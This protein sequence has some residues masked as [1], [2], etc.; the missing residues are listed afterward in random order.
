MTLLHLNTVRDQLPTHIWEFASN[1]RHYDLSSYES[2]HD[3]WL[4]TLTIGEPRTDSNLRSVGIEICLLGAYH[5]RCH[6]LAYSNVRSFSMSSPGI[7]NG[8][9]DLITHE[10][11]L[12]DDGVFIIHELL[13]AGHLDASPSSVIIECADFRIST[14]MEIEQASRGYM[15]PASRG[16][17]HTRWAQLDR[18]LARNRTSD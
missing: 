18:P 8:H 16:S 12:A 17:S 15:A 13:F 6:T 10:T 1:S 14:K 4:D 9:G 11:R 2:L 5:D 7:V 3:A